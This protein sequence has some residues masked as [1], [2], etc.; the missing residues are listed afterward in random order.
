MFGNKRSHHLRSFDVR[1]QSAH[2]RVSSS[3]SSV[4][5]LPPSFPAV[6]EAPPNETYILKGRLWRQQ[7]TRDGVIEVV[8]VR[9]AFHLGQVQVGLAEPLRVAQGRAL[10]LR[11]N[12]ELPMQVDGE[13]RLISP[14]ELH[15]THCAQFP[16]LHPADM[17]AIRGSKAPVSGIDGQARVSVLKTVGAA[18]EGA[19]SRGDLSY[20]QRLELLNEIATGI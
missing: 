9:S 6:L 7:S 2:K 15:I 10:V 3:S 16:V 4:I 8:G 13:P 19:V 1:A 17:Q 11:I 20:Q 18:L 14:C 5:A 12:T